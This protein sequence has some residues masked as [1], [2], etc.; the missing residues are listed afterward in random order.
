VLHFSLESALLGPA[1]T[2]SSS[3]LKM[4]PV[5]KQL[6]R[7]GLGRHQIADLLEKHIGDGQSEY[8]CK[9]ALDALMKIDD[10]QFLSMI[11]V[12]RRLAYKSNTSCTDI[13]ALAIVALR[14]SHSSLQRSDST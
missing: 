3:A 2:L 4:N 11:R 14:T 1:R 7:R 6:K 8:L 5:L 9:Q 10:T 12:T 13:V